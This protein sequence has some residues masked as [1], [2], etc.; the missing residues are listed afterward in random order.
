MVKVNN[1]IDRQETTS[2]EVPSVS[3]ASEL[4]PEILSEIFLRVTGR[5]IILSAL[6]HSKGP[7]FLG[8]VCS[9]W[10]NV[11]KNTPQIWGNIFVDLDDHILPGHHRS[12]PWINIVN[13]SMYFIFST[14]T[15]LLDLHIQH[16]AYIGQPEFFVAYTNRLRGLTLENCLLET[17]IWFLNLPKNSFPFLE[18]IVF[19]VLTED[20]PPTPD[21]S[22]LQ[23]APNL[24]SVTYQSMGLPGPNYSLLPLQQIMELYVQGVQVSL[25][26]VHEILVSSPSLVICQFLN[27]KNGSIS[28]GGGITML[29]L[30]MLM[31]RTMD[32][33]DWNQL[34][35]SIFA[36]QL[37]DLL[38][39][40]PQV[41][42]HPTILLLEKSNCPLVR[43]ILL[44]PGSH[45][46]HD[47]REVDYLIDQL[48][49]CITNLYIPIPVS[50]S[51][52]RR[53]SHGE[54]PMLKIFQGEVNA[55]GLELLVELIDSYADGTALREQSLTFI[56]V[57]VWGVNS[58]SVAH[59]NL[60][61]VDLWKEI[62][63]LKIIIQ[64]QGINIVL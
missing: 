11:L 41:P 27:I 25:T 28:V 43:L 19:D 13:E 3:R 63:G 60:R 5:K 4:I 16:G 18:R 12:R 58:D 51:I 7:W 40:S 15:A 49:A 32:E 42:L 47:L 9:H 14:T 57:Q 8:H 34:L 24:H 64:G 17:Y 53:M 23:S 39:A 22:P 44:S 36:P 45:N 59:Y 10:R 35:P 26:I 52:F 33:L 6:Y 61:G 55:E 29:F 46:A 2:S 31:L 56:E 62:K 21:T 20:A 1:A 38:I 50:G 54:F 37:E 48:P 30:K